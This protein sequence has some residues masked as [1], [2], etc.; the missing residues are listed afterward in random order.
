MRI[1]DRVLVFPLG[2]YSFVCPLLCIAHRCTRVISDDGNSNEIGWEDVS[3]RLMVR[4]KKK[5]KKK[6]NAERAKK[7]KVGQHM[8]IKEEQ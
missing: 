2:F 8:V 7:K 6:K 4:K 3:G 5:K 1:W